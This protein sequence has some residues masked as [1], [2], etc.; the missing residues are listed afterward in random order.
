M[1]FSRLGRVMSDDQLP[2]STN[3]STEPTDERRLSKEDIAKHLADF[4]K[5][6]EDMA[7]LPDKVDRLMRSFF[8]SAG[9]YVSKVMTIGY[10]GFFGIWAMTRTIMKPGPVLL[11]ASLMLISISI[12]V[13]NEIYNVS[14]LNKVAHGG[15]MEGI[16]GVTEHIGKLS[17]TVRKYQGMQQWALRVT[18]AFACAAVLVMVYALVVDLWHVYLGIPEKAKP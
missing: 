5:L 3:T 11:T 17:A 2:N 16:K 18:L 7:A 4:K 14:M 15:G 10:A 9:S 8:E 6:A 13:A 12:F 1:T